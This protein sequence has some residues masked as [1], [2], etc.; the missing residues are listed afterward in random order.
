MFTAEN[1][2]F[3][4]AYLALSDFSNGR[5]RILIVCG[6]WWKS[7][8][9][10]IEHLLTPSIFLSTLD[11]LSSIEDMLFS[12]HWNVSIIYSRDGD[13]Y[14]TLSNYR[15]FFFI[16][17]RSKYILSVARSSKWRAG[18]GP[19]RRS[20]VLAKKKKTKLRHVGQCVMNPQGFL[21][22]Y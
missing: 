2:K 5:N 19:K 17:L 8:R 16:I 12:S 20:K 14:L 4:F 7:S 21:P 9:F 3:W 6:D 18:R 13:F 15:N 11:R 22:E 1:R 10:G